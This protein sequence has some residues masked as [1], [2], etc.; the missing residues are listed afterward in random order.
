LRE[1]NQRGI[2][3]RMADK[4]YSDDELKA[5]RTSPGWQLEADETKHEGTLEDV[6][7]IAHERHQRGEHPGLIKEIENSVELEM[8]QLEQLWRALGL[9]V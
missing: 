9:P 6:A 8:L 2:V 7:R 4:T 5:R 1:R 3:A